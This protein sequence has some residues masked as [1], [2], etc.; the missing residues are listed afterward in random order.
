MEIIMQGLKPVVRFQFIAALALLAGTAHGARANDLLAVNRVRFLPATGHEKAMLGGTICG[1]NVSSQGGFEV[2]A[3]IKTVEPGKWNELTFINSKP[4]RW[5]KYQAPTGSS[6]WISKIEFYADKEQ[7]HG[8]VFAAYPPGIWRRV[9]DDR[10]VVN[11]QG[12]KPDGQYV[13]IDIGERAS[14][15]RPT[16]SPAGGELSRPVIVTMHCRMPEAVIRYTTD[17]TL[18]TLDTGKV[19]SA[20]ISID[21]T[22]T[23]TAAAFCEGLAPSPAVDN[24]YLFNP[25]RRN[26]LHF[27]NSLSGNAVGKFALYTRTAGVIH[28]PTLISMGGGL[29]RTL[30]NSA[31][32]GVGDPKD[33]AR[34]GDLFTATHSMGGVV[35]YSLLQVKAVA[36]RWKEIWPKQ[37]QITD[38]T[39]Q[40]RDADIP[41]EADYT[42]RWLKVVREKSPE[43][44]PWLYIE[45]TERERKR[46]T[47]LGELPSS[48]MSK[49]YPALTWEESMSAMMLYGEEVQLA[50]SRLDKQG[51]HVRIIPTALAMGWIHH[52]IQ[53]GA[54]P[55]VGPDG[56]ESLLF[57][58]K[59]HVNTEGSYLVDTTWYAALYG[60]SPEGKLLPLRANLTSK[61]AT[62]MQRLAWDV[63]ENYPDCGFYRQGT[64]PVGK[65][66]FSPTSSNIKDVTRV[67]LSSATPGAWFRYTLDGTEPTRTRGY[68]YCGVV[69]VRPGMTLRAVAYKSGMADSPV[70]DSIYPK[71][72]TIGDGISK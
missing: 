39:F 53:Q 41:E 67:T 52:Q 38:V 70:A 18:P 22:T 12:D 20:P 50:L 66:Q 17:G 21:K 62:A 8:E 19:Y 40:P 4:Y 71:A 55:D 35:T 26:T 1:S 51:K 2:L 56:F 31:M 24:I 59:V 32:I 57:A 5:I 3:E 63:V 6:G 9:M 37:S 69:S 61:Q 43:V 58:D 28:E 33:Q 14:C 45:W 7:L 25:T 42:D 11:I 15:P 16:F 65:P 44:Q 49:V 36:D 27:G 23:F 54:F 10:P 72:G 29:A 46:A 68:I 34:W 60:Q 48:Q 30:W 64:E 47:D 13:G